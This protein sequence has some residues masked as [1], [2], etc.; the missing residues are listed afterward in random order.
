MNGRWNI[1]LVMAIGIVVGGMV[2]MV[3]MDRRAE[4]HS[5]QYTY[6]EE[7]ALDVAMRSRSD[8]A[9]RIGDRACD[10]LYPDMR[11]PQ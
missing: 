7:C 1:A 10:E 5:Y 9:A 6:Y 4:T 11:P 3:L 2:T 8:R